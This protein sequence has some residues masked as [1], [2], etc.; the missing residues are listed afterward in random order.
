MKD[1]LENS[2]KSFLDNPSKESLKR[3]LKA[4]LEEFFEAFLRVS[5]WQSLRETLRDFLEETV[6]VI[7]METYLDDSLDNSFIELSSASVIGQGG[8]SIT[9]I[10]HAECFFDWLGGLR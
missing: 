5:R 1:P 10:K 7:H 3:L 9:D 6:T 4:F 2:L 8:R